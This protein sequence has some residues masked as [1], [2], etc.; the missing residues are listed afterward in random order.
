MER[1]AGLLKAFVIGCFVSGLA[2]I[3]GAMLV[4]TALMVAGV[5]VTLGIGP[6]P[7]MAVCSG[8]N[9]YGYSSDWGL[10]VV[11][12]LGGATRVVQELRRPSQAEVVD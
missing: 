9:G 6:V 8:P 12:L 11:P 10:A 4:G 1:S 3:A 5:T 2:A 7:F